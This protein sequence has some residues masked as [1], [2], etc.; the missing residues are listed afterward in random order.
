MQKSSVLVRDLV[1]IGGGHTHALVARMWGMK[2]VEGVRL[3]LI[4]P[5]PTAPYSGMLPGYIAGHYSRE[6]LEIDLVKLARFAGA[7]LVLG[8]A[9]MIDPAAGLVRVSGGREI[10]WDVASI[11]IGI[12]AQMPEIEGFSEHGTG[13]KP[14]DLYAER[15][16]DFR[17]RALAGKVAAEV[18]VIGGG[19]A[20][21]ELAL[22]MAY[23]LRAAGISAKV[24][25]IEAGPVIASANPGARKALHRAMDGL[26]VQVL[27]NATPVRIDSDAVHLADGRVVASS[28]TL[29][30]AG[31]RAHGW[32]ARAP[33]PVTR[34][35]FVKVGPD[36]QVEGHRN[37]FAAGDCAHM[38]HAPR[39]KAGVF[40]VR[41]APVLYRNLGAAVTGA[42]MRRFNP[43]KYY[44]KLISLGG[45]NA[46]VEKWGRAVAG[47]A[48]W[49][50]KNRIDLKFMEKFHSLPAMAT[51]PLAPHVA[52]VLQAEGGA[53]DRPL[54]GGCGSK[55][56][57]G[58]LARALTHLPKV[59]RADV[60]SAPGD[61]AAVLALEK[62]VRQVLTTDHLRAFTNDHA[63]LARIAAV[64]ALGDIWAM[65]AA[66]QAAL[67][68]VT[69][70]R[71]SEALQA[72]S[73]D[74]I[75]AA[76]AD[77]LNG[78]GVEIV[79]GHSAMGAEMSIGLSLT[80]LLDR[81]PLM[82]SGAQAGDV[83][84]L[85][86]PIGSGTLLAAE[87]QG[88]ADGRDV[89]ELLARM[90]QPQGDAARLLAEAGARAMTDV[91]GFGLAGHLQG[92]CRA[93]ALDARL[94]LDAVPT[95]P[96]ALE[97]VEAGHRST[98]WMANNRAAPVAG[99]AGARAVLL[100]D[101]QTAGGMLAAVPNK[102]AQSLV[103]DLEA[104]GHDAA[105]IGDMI[106]GE[107][108]VFVEPG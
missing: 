38:S 10:A 14:L 46:I 99:A 89:A 80:G 54:C 88:A 34:D 100:H 9:E 22:A 92:M 52:R 28:F 75:L 20:G 96:G 30:A 39:P 74:E 32:L 108:R 21:A 94:E 79:G 29:G 77:V 3:T 8:H 78:Q 17:A 81:T 51:A 107:G 55:V 37:L 67:L 1:L 59:G 24:S 93:S 18:A 19:I 104:A 41:A 98:I 57:P 15:W 66:P 62:G 97:M 103:G 102:V 73:M 56:G 13:A 7:R 44:L 91:T 84:I 106:A 76:M 11:D 35:G 82:L 105:I 50:W 27:V 86:R 64:H 61:D 72:R 58:T 68:S 42:K 47:P 45:K 101:P 23:A 65:G 6:S 33:L 4:N 40:A 53:T 49:R 95:Y 2:P 87:M 26:G 43:Q 48:L 70:P 5:H 69:L 63:L 83:L 60:R 71:M 16:E 25:L 12:H 36:L 85:S 90:A 31:A